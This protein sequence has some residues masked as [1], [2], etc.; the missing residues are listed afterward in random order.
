MIDHFRIV[1]LDEIRSHGIYFSFDWVTKLHT[2]YSKRQSKVWVYKAFQDSQVTH[3]KAHSGTNEACIGSGAS[4]CLHM[5]HETRIP[6]LRPCLQPS[7]KWLVIS[8]ETNARN[9][10]QPIWKF[11]A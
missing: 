7:L 3:N 11:F 2:V 6:F 10:F 8:S 4:C 5:T 1:Y 9:M